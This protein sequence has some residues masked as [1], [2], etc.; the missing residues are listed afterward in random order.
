M[1]ATGQ[2]A[3][4]DPSDERHRPM[5][6]DTLRRLEQRLDEASAAAE[7]LIAEAAASAARSGADGA[8]PRPPSAGWQMPRSDGA[9]EDI[10]V[11]AQFLRSVR[12]LIPPELQR[13][14]AEAFRELL[15]ALRALLDWYLDR[16]APPQSPSR[17]RTSRSS[18]HTLRG[19]ALRGPTPSAAPPSRPTA[20]AACASRT[21]RTAASRASTSP[22]SFLSW[23]QVNRS[24][25]Q[26]LAARAASRARSFSNARRVP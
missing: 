20:Y 19:H 22:G 3:N 13:R 2:M 5:A 16:T 10:D 4:E 9:R 24:T 7:R 25:S 12:D 23:R 17:S 21:A 18:D 8:D 26:P 6:Y 15:L 1:S 14:L 11:L